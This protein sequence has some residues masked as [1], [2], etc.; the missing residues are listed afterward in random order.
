MQFTPPAAPAT[1]NA[2]ALTPQTTP[3]PTVAPI[4]FTPA[5]AA[6]APAAPPPTTDQLFKNIDPSIQQ[7]YSKTLGDALTGK[8]YDPTAQGQQE[9]LARQE[10][11]G[12][13]S[14]ADQL[15]KAGMAGEGI[16]KSISSAEEDKL[17]K[18]RF[19][20]NIGIDKARADERVA[21]LGEARAFGTAEQQ[22]GGQAV[23]T[24]T[25]Q[26]NLDTLKR[27]DAGSALAADITNHP[28]WITNPNAALSDPAFMNAAQKAW[29]ASGQKGQVPQDWA[30]NQV[31]AVTTS[32]N[33][34]LMANKQVEQLVS[35]GTITADQ[36]KLLTDFNSQG[37]SQYLQRNPDGTVSVNWDK[38]NKDMN[39]SGTTGTGGGTV[40]KDV[41]VPVDPST[42]KPFAQDKS[43][44]DN[45]KLYTVNSQNQPEETT[46]DPS[47]DEPT[48]TKAKSILAAGQTG[49]PL[50]QEVYDSVKS[51]AKSGNVS[52]EDLQGLPPD[53]PMLVAAKEGLPT[54]SYTDL[55]SKEGDLKK[56]QLVKIKV[57]GQDM[58]VRYDG[59]WNNSGKQTTLTKAGGQKT[60]LVQDTGESFTTPDGKPVKLYAGGFSVVNG[61]QV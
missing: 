30:L 4:K 56:G 25:A 3:A 14:I 50:Y 35:S 59:T 9:A 44:V 42:G 13:A 39:I 31:K 43:F 33:T 61:V 48:G 16:G 19:D 6:P 11:Q 7:A 45:G 15:A 40:A 24:A 57:G 2:P 23:A 54:S 38:Y 27:T 32:S 8:I 5:P 10:K 17:R 55:W 28:D 36:G 20:T 21:A 1:V 47:T 53:S 12:R 49:N 41:T 60:S 22:A 58:V 26:Q 37:G 51:A 46:F 18:Q 29:E 34:T 52:Y